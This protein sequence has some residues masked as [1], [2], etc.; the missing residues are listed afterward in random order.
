[1]ATSYSHFPIRT[2]PPFLQVFDSTFNLIKIGSSCNGV[3]NGGEENVGIGLLNMLNRSL[4]IHDFFPLIAPHEKHPGLNATRST[5]CD[6]GLHLFDS[7]TALHG[8][9]DT[10]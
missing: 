9:Q 3:S 8:V 2:N 6:R 10:L 4:D 7:D 1:M 5:Q